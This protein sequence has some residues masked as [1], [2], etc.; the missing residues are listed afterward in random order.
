MGAGLKTGNTA[1]ITG[2]IGEFDTFMIGKA[3]NDPEYLQ[4]LIK[5]AQ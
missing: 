5:E 3:I 4:L 1:I 2:M